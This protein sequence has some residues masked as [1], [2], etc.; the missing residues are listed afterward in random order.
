[1]W[2]PPAPGSAAAPYLSRP[3]TTRVRRPPH[4]VTHTLQI[5][6]LP[7][8]HGHYK[9][10][11]RAP[12][13]FIPQPAAE[14]ISCHLSLGKLVSHFHSSSPLSPQ[15]FTAAI[16]TELLRGILS[17][18]SLRCITA[19]SPLESSPWDLLQRTSAKL[20]RSPRC[21]H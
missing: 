9:Y 1:M 8:T 18:L 7:H 16:P 14:R 17:P 12:R 15:C 5:H 13:S 3:V 21:F 10:A 6:A 19:G 20:V 4:D 11:L 2:Q